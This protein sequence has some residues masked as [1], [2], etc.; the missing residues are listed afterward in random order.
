MNGL[1]SSFA[2]ES[3]CSHEVVTRAVK[4]TDEVGGDSKESAKVE[5]EEGER[6]ELKRKRQWKRKRERE[7]STVT[8]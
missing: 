3:R 8:L 1:A 6:K 2:S 5:E 7:L 4:E